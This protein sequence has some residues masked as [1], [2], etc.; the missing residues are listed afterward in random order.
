MSGPPPGVGGGAT[1][2]GG[3]PNP[4][5]IAAMKEAGVRAEFV[6]DMGMGMG[7]YIIGSV[8]P[9]SLTPPDRI[10]RVADW[11]DTQRI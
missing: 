1:G 8:P 5:Q 3:P 10:T 2:G 11:I 9:R 6:A 4:A 7:P